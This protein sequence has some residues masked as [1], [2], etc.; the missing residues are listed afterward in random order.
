MTLFARLGLAALMLASALPMTALAA[1]DDS[2]RL[3]ALLA[4]M[5]RQDRRAAQLPLLDA[6]SALRTRNLTRE[7]LP[8]VSALASGQYVS[9]VPAIGGVPMVPYQQYDAYVTVRQR[10]F[11]PSRRPRAEL[12]RAQFDEAEAQVRGRLWQQRSQ[13]NDAFFTLLAL[14]AER[15]TLGRRS[16]NSRRTAGSPPRDWRPA[17]R[18]P[19]TSHCWTRNSCAAGSPS[20]TSTPPARPRA[21]SSPR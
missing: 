11:D 2:L 20:T 1:Q 12:E 16:P 21:P 4:A 3:P 5:Q 8:S 9:D 6:Q 10:L 17:P 14:D 7:Q 13:V 15:R 19:A 18:S